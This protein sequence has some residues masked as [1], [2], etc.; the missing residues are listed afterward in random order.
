M[1]TNIFAPPPSL[2]QGAP[3]TGT[4]MQVIDAAAAALLSLPVD[5]SSVAPSLQADMTAAQALATQWQTVYR[6]QVEATLQ[7]ILN[8][9]SEFQAV[10]QTLYSESEQIAAGDTS[11]IPPFQ[12]NLANLQKMT[13]NESATATFVQNN[14]LAYSNQVATSQQALNSDE[15]LINNAIVGDQVEL[16]AD[17]QAMNVLYDK[18]S[19]LYWDIIKHQGSPLLQELTIIMDEIDH[20]FSILNEQMDAVSTDMDANEQDLT[21]LTSSLTTLTGYLTDLSQLQSGLGSLT[22]GWEEITGDFENLLTD[23]NITSYSVFTPDDILAAA[24]DWVE[25]MVLVQSF[26]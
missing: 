16:Q 23:E 1:A 7:G 24:K 18:Q 13:T 11:A 14:L 8:Y 2:V 22:T 12:A 6:L 4:A 9:G 10:F 3:A 5:T 26:V 19:E 21:S 15:V 25:L 20:A 17:Q